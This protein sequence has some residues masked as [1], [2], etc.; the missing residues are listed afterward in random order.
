MKSHFRHSSFN[1]FFK[2]PP[3][4]KEPTVKKL[5]PHFLKSKSKKRM[6]DKKV[7]SFQNGETMFE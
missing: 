4:V 3:V 2:K 1:I 6:Q 7:F 5:K